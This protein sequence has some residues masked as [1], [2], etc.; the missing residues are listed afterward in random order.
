MEKYDIYRDIA[1]RTQGDIYIGVVG[2]VRTGK[3][4]LIKRIMDLLVLPNI[5]NAYK[6]ERAKDELPQSGTGKTITTTEPKFVPNEAVEL[7][8]KDNAS[9]RLRMID[10]VGYLVKGAIGHQEEGKSRMVNTPW[11]EKQI[12]FEEAAEI[13]TKKVIQEHS[14]IGLV[15]TTDGTVTDI[16][17]ESYIEAEERVIKELKEI[18]KPFIMILN[19]Q[20]TD[21]PA[22]RELKDQLE[23]KHNVPVVIKNCAKLTM[24]DIH[25]ILENVLFEFPVT[26]ININL[27]GWLESIES[28]HWLKNS[29]LTAIKSSAANVKRLR[30]IQLLVNGLNEVENV[31]KANLDGIKMGEGSALIDLTTP[32]NL[33]YTVIQE[34]TGYEIDGDYQLIGMITE[35]AKAKR[36]YDRIERALND[37]MTIGYGLVPPSLDELTLEEPEMFRHGNQF[38]VKLRANAPSLHFIRADITT[39]VSPVVG[40]EKQSEELIKYLLEEF[41]QN[42]EKIWET[43]MFGKSLHDLVKEQ[44]QNKLFMVPDDTR[45]KLQKTIQKIVNDGSGGL[46]AII[47]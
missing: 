20:N 18:N 42:P 38:G 6:K 46:I 34:K 35:L 25:E 37:V 36:E 22:T 44:L 14:T 15:V 12:P 30:D 41:E 21:S 28:S 13:G 17:R 5:E 11:F 2:P 23:A 10:C 43:N 33:F 16:E 40:T 32:E 39:E 9:F 27:P 1:K 19:T 7:T 8:L 29:I 3:S 4:T 31:K 47:L 24:N 26:E 45:V